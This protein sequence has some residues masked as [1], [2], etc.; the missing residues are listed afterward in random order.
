MTPMLITLSFL[1][2][3]SFGAIVTTAFAGHYHVTCVGHGFVHGDA[4]A[5]ESFFARVEYGCGAG[6]NR[7]CSIYTSGSLRGDQVVGGSATCNLWSFSLGE[8]SECA[9]TSH[10]GYGGLFATHVHKAHNW[11]G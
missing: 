6:G 2:A 11:C 1:C 8:L 10:V 4:V 3:F 9:S 5:D 7:N